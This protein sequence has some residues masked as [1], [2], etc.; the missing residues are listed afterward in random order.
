MHV[1]SLVF[2]LK[3]T[4]HCHIYIDTACV[5]KLWYLSVYYSDPYVRISLYR[6]DR[7]HGLLDTTTTST[8]KKVNMIHFI[9]LVSSISPTLCHLHPWYNLQPL[10]CCHHH[11][12]HYHHLFPNPQP[13]SSSVHQLLLLQQLAIN[14]IS[15]QYC[16]LTF[17]LELNFINHLTGRHFEHYSCM[18]FGCLFTYV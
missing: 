18:I 11:H 14:I 7:D 4:T 6:G 3:Y 13:L 9:I 1:W 17:P 12:H 8:I 2:I 15:L 5:F 16:L 10:H